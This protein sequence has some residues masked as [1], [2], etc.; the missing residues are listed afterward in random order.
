ME[1]YMNKPAPRRTEDTHLPQEF[2][3]TVAHYR[4]TYR[5]YAYLFQ[6]IYLHA[7]ATNEHGSSWACGPDAGFMC[8]D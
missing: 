1:Y 3:F 8:R 2:F 6:F 7:L 4:H 5:L